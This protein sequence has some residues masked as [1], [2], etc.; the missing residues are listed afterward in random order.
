MK[1][2]IDSFQKKFKIMSVIASFRWPILKC[3]QVVRFQVPFDIVEGKPIPF[4][5]D[6]T[7]ERDYT[8]IDDIIEGI[9]AAMNK[10]GGYE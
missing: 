8:Y 10:L 1:K 3:P 2:P 9:I 6:G 4:Y 5:G 7:S